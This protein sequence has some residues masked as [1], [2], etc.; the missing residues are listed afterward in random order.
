MRTSIPT[1]IPLSGFIIYVLMLTRIVAYG[2]NK[3]TPTQECH[4]KG[5]YFLWYENICTKITPITLDHK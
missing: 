2:W 1:I 5:G 4:R 3:E